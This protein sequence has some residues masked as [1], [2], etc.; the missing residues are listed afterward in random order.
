MQREEPLFLV[1]EDFDATPSERRF[2]YVISHS[3]LSHAA[4]SQL[5]QF[6]GAVAA[7]LAV[8]GTAVVSI[9]FSDQDGRLTGDSCSPEWV[10]PGTS[11]Y[12]PETAAAAAAGVGLS[13]DWVPEY[14]ERM[15]KRAPSNFH[16]W[17]RLRHLASRGRP[18]SAVG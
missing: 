5:P 9:R 4:E 8:G 7:S 1:N 13:C 16:D 2:D 17:I 18:T 15:V 12:A 6:M 3:I 14:R 11:S 10:Y